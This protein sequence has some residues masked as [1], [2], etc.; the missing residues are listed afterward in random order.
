VEPTDRRGLLGAGAAAALGLSTIT[1]APTAASGVDPE[2]PA[3][4]TNLLRLLG[5]HDDMFGPRGVLEIVRREIAIIA[6]HREG[7]TGDLRIALMRVE[8]RW[9]DLAAALSEDT[10]DS[11]AAVWADRALQLARASRDPDMVAFA[12]ARHSLHVGT[13]ARATIALSEG[14]LNVRGAS[15]QTRAWCARQAARGYARI[16]DAD[17]CER[18]IADAYTLLEVADSPAP[19][20]ASGYRVTVIGT[21]AREA[22]CWAALDPRKAIPLYERALREW[23]RSEA[24]DGG[25]YRARLAI[26]CAATGERDRAEAEG[27]KALA[28]ARATQ[29]SA[30]D[31]ELRQL[32]GLLN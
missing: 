7:A 14:G 22:T 15:A 26:V 16:G 12:R 24:R 10:G 31:R 30:I 9:A 17:A 8:A 1:S 4:W 32:G 20:W 25:L 5:R 11:S 29:S 28:I 2:L 6:A 23:P 18:R 19:P 13:D 27:R 21:L 3:H